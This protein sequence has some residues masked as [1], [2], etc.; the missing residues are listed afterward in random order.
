MKRDDFGTINLKAI[1]ETTRITGSLDDDFVFYN[2]ITQFPAWIEC[3]KLNMFAVVMCVKGRLDVEINSYLHSI[4]SR[5][6]IIGRPNDLVAN[7]RV[8][9]D[10][11]GNVFCV[12]QNLIHTNLSHSALWNRALR[13]MDNPIVDIS[14]DK[15]KLYQLYD[16]ILQRK[17]TL[18]DKSPYDRE[19]IL[20]VVRAA[21]FELLADMG[22]MGDRFGGGAVRQREILFKRFIELL[23][24]VEVRPRLVAWYA[25]QLCVT[26]KYLSTVCRNVSGRTAFD[27]INSYVVEDIRRYLKY[28]DMTV[29]E[30]SNRLLFPNL[31]F[32]GKYVKTHFGESPTA[33]RVKLRE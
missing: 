12:S 30:I 5:Q 13:V 16:G 21:L 4:A 25:R 20:S 15:I 1:V 32:F 7:L 28:S 26:P 31:S 19:I 23:N 9:D 18:S 10:F 14:S 17:A 11:K 33:L 24:R 6:V 27:W 3:M 2:D 8:S 22:E 29:K